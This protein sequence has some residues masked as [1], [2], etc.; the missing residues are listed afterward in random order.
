MVYE[1]Y[2]IFS[3][4][5]TL[6]VPT[7]TSFVFIS[8]VPFFTYRLERTDIKVYDR[9]SYL[10]PRYCDIFFVVRIRFYLTFR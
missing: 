7:I 10:W 1:L 3:I 2:T 6:S 4:A 5:K 9:S 8:R